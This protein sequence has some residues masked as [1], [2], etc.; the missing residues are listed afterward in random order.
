MPHRARLRAS[1]ADREYIAERLRQATS[2]GRLRPDE[3]E[4]RL[5]AALSATTYGELDVLVTDLPV[6][7]LTR[8]HQPQ[9]LPWV[10][11]VLALAI[12]LPLALLIIAA[13]AFILTGLFAAWAFW[14]LLGWWFFFGRHARAR[15]AY[16][17]RG[18]ACRSGGPY[19]VRHMQ[20][21]PGHWL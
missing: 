1:D 8:R 7:S 18:R 6:S 12:A 13:V 19:D 16:R 4:E 5:G 21:R 2:E 20:T 11:A 14:V 10:P 3:L 17:S 9:L 15:R